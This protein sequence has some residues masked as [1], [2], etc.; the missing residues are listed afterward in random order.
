MAT[1]NHRELLEKWGL[2]GLKLSLGFLEAEFKPADADRNAAW[3]LYV[4]LLTRVTTQHLLPDDGDEKIALDSV[5]ALF[6]LTRDILKRHGSGCIEFAKLA[7]PVLNQIVR[8][9]TARWHKRALAGGFN[10]AAQRATFRAELAQ[11][12]PVLMR[13][14]R[15]LADLAQVED[16]T[17]LE[18]D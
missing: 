17:T 11:L 12:Q 4:E 16:L 1:L 6:A 3:E 7:V 5:Y 18:A 2:S 9:F 15:A 14:A 13:Y 10:D 8:P